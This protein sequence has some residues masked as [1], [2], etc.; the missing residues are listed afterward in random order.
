MKKFINLI[1]II[2]AFLLFFTAFDAFFNTFRN[3]SG[4][5]V[6]SEH[7]QRRF[8]KVDLQ[9]IEILIKQNRL[10]NHE[11]LFYERLENNP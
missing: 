2:F 7:V 11:A 9:K 8:R 1:V 6:V 10:S 5:I 3:E 4:S